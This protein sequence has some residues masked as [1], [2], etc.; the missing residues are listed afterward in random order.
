MPNNDKISISINNREPFI[1]FS[2][3]FTVFDQIISSYKDYDL[4]GLNQAYVY[5]YLYSFKQ[6]GSTI[7]RSIEEK[8]QYV[9]DTINVNQSL[10]VA[11][12]YAIYSFIISR[13]NNKFEILDEAR[14]FFGKNGYYLNVCGH[15]GII[16][17]K[18]LGFVLGLLTISNNDDI[19]N[20]VIKNAN[21]ESIDEEIFILNYYLALKINQIEFDEDDAKRKAAMLISSTRVSALEK[22]PAL[23]FVEKPEEYFNEVVKAFT[24]PS[25]YYNLFNIHIDWNSSD[26]SSLQPISIVNFLMVSR[27][28]GWD[29]L[30]LVKPNLLENAKK[31]KDK[32]EAIVLEKG[33]IKRITNN[34]E[35]ISGLLGAIISADIILYIFGKILYGAI[36][37]III[38]VISII[39]GLM[40]KKIFTINSDKED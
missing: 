9:K 3:P 38:S 1:P 27:M 29:K 17:P 25:F 10:D 11:A 6:Q 8:Y 5:F 40:D 33:Y 7:I 2:G 32:K 39:L 31:L 28:L 18:Q 30:E 37:S 35:V 36:G 24:N 19:Y 21:H 12:E 26:F 4:I 14:N 22:I 20:N 16:L 13:Y 23:I 15:S 34:L